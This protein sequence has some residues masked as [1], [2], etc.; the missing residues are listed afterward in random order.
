MTEILDEQIKS[1]I[2]KIFEQ[3]NQPVHVLFFGKKINCETC[4]ETRQLAEEVIALSDK[5][6][7]TAYD[8][9][10]DQVVAQQHRV[11]KSPTLVIAG[12]ENDLI[13]DYGIR[14][15]GTPSGHEFVAFIHDLVLV[16]SR[17]SGLSLTTREFL[18]TLTSPVN[19]QVFVTPT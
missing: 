6:S 12:A 9:E 10:D 19:L 14:Y 5:L 4:A 18:N 8:L 3:L 15:S 16:S 17:D 1:Q 7:M 11:D 13:L 2:L